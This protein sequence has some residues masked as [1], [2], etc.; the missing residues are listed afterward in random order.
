[1]VLLFILKD[2]DP[3]NVP[4]EHFLYND[5]LA[6]YLKLNWTEF[7]SSTDEKPLH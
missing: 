2:N 1:M 4:I 5:S 7:D 6:L 3:V